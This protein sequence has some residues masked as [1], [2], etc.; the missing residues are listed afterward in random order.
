MKRIFTI[1]AITLTMIFNVN[2]V[3]SADIRNYDIYGSECT[4]EDIVINIDG[5]RINGVEVTAEI[6]DIGTINY[7]VFEYG[8]KIYY[9]T[10]DGSVLYTLPLSFCAKSTNA[11]MQ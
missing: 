2:T 9:V 7:L 6:E 3:V 8:D 11:I 1:I 5:Q 4:V 10:K